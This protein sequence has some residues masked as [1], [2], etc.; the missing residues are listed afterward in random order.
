M[1]YLKKKDIKKRKLFKK[2]EKLK[3]IAKY[4]RINLI[5]NKCFFKKIC[6]KSF[7]SFKKFKKYSKVR[8]TRRCIKENRNRGV[9][10]VFNVSRITLRRALQFGLISG[11]KKSVW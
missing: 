5:K 6:F 10:R 11:Y 1:L 7:K 3:I 8:I 2:F 9:S 4:I